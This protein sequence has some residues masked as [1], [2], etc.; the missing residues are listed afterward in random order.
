MSK[1]RI[2]RQEQ[3]C[4]ATGES[5]I[6]NRD[7]QVYKNMAVQIKNNNEQAKLKRMELKLFNDIIITNKEKL[8]R[9]LNYMILCKWKSIPVAYID[10]EGLNFEVYTSTTKNSETK[11]LVYWCLNF[12]FEPVDERMKLYY[13]Y[14]K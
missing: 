8:V 10:Y 11:K 4:P 14:K 6:P 7:N 1:T 9:L 13:I 2:I 5:F 12:G 3:V